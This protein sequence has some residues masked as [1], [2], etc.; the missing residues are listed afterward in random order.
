MALL[1]ISH[2]ERNGHHYYRG[3]SMFPQAWQEALLAAH[4]DLYRRHEDG[5]VCLRIEEGKV[6]LD[7][8]NAAPFGVA[9]LLDP[10]VLTQVSLEQLSV[11][12][13]TPS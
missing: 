7:S 9:P 13:P 3:L 10:A 12:R 11:H 5:F 8:V 2:V 4:G 6:Q 1:G